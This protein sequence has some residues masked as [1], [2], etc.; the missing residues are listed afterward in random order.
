MLSS[1]PG[2]QHN[3]EGDLWVIVDSKVFDLSKFAPLHPGGLSVLLEDEVRKCHIYHP[4]TPSL[5]L[6]IREARSNVVFQLEFGHCRLQ[7]GKT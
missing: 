4:L 5:A 7:E 3:K 1:R 2:L 6:Y